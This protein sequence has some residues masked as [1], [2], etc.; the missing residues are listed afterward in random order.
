MAPVNRLFQGFA[1]GSCERSAPGAGGRSREGCATRLFTQSARPGNTRVPAAR[2]GS[3]E[4]ASVL[5][6]PEYPQNA[7]VTRCR[8][9]AGIRVHPIQNTVAAIAGQL[10]RTWMFTHRM[11]TRVR[12]QLI[13]RQPNRGQPPSCRQS[14]ARL[15]QPCANH[16]DIG[17]GPGGV[18]QSARHI[19]R[20]GRGIGNSCS[21]PKLSIQAWT[22]AESTKRPASISVSASAIRSASH[23]MR[24]RLAASVS[25][26]GVRPVAGSIVFMA[27]SCLIV[28]LAASFFIAR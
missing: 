13:S 3:K 7:H 15:H 18:D 22:S 24:R 21:V 27:A 14:R 1:G 5:T 16:G 19:Q 26:E 8:I 20:R 6:R 12:T 28:S 17:N 25:A 2:D 23:A 9:A 4:G 10:A 11:R